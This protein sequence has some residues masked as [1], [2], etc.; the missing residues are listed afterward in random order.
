MVAI[1][2]LLVTLLIC[3]NVHS[4]YVI[5]TKGTTLFLAR[6]SKATADVPPPISISAPFLE[7]VSE[8]AE[9]SKGNGMLLTS[10]ESALPSEEE[11]Q[12][13]EQAFSALAEESRRVSGCFILRRPKIIA[14][15]SM[16]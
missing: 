6:R 13:S 9:E 14:H 16:T 1:F 2:Y 8:K 3:K 4:Y 7:E 11:H 15:Y 10:E 12:S 5:S